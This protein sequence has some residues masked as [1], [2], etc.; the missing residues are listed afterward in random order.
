MQGLDMRL[1]NA[2]DNFSKVQS[3]KAV[4]ELKK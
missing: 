2:A 3:T 4:V 1:K